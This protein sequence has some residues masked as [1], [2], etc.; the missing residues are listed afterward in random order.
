MSYQKT[1]YKKTAYNLLK[2]AKITEMSSG[3]FEIVVQ[4]KTPMGDEWHVKNN[5]YN[6]NSYGIS[7][8]NS[9]YCL[10]HA[11]VE[12]TITSEKLLETLLEKIENKY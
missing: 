4:L 10:N 8:Y 11:I 1:L 7:L 3:N 5:C 9:C 12:H 6:N 2:N